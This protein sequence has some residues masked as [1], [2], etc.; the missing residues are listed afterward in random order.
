MVAGRN[1][2]PPIRAVLESD[3][4]KHKDKYSTKVVSSQF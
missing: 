4:T 1:A 2:Q 3:I